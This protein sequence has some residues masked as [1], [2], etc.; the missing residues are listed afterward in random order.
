MVHRRLL[1][2][3][4]VLDRDGAGGVGAAAGRSALVT[5]TCGDCAVGPA[6]TADGGRQGNPK[7]G[8]ADRAITTNERR[9]P[10]SIGS[11][12]VAEPVES[13][14]GHSTLPSLQA[15][16]RVDSRGL[17]G[18]GCGWGAMRHWAARSRPRPTPAPRSSWPIV[19]TYRLAAVS[20]LNQTGAWSDR[21]PA[22]TSARFQTGSTWAW[23]TAA[24][25]SAVAMTW[26]SW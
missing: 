22:S 4:W 21:L 12:A 20:R 1:T 18:R 24:A 2:V 25:R 5:S 10:T 7:A 13:A 15:V 16:L 19:P 26:S 23:L 14:S 8:T 3:A 11:P 17:P 9:H 6:A